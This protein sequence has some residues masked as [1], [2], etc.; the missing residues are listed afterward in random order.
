VTSRELLPEILGELDTLC[1]RERETIA[2]GA[3]S[4]VGECIAL[5]ASD[6]VADGFRHDKTPRTPLSLR[7][8]IEC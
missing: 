3:V 6:V 4:G 8:S 7:R 1:R 2:E 5:L